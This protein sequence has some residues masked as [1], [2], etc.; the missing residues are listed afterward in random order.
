MDLGSRFFFFF[1][2]FFFFPSPVAEVPRLGIE[3]KPQQQ[4]ELLQ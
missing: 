3:P 1:S 2:F 4:P